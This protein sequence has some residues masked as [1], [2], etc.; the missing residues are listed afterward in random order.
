MN[1]T[2]LSSTVPRALEGKS[3]IFGFEISDVLVLFTNLSIQNLIFG[4]TAFKAVMVWGTTLVLGFV[5]FFVKRGKP[6]KYLKHL[7]EYVVSPS[8]RFAGLNDRF[9]KQLNS[10]KVKS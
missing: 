8:I 5:L 7:G 1:T 2:L 6:E 10:R 3:K 9:Y 4:E